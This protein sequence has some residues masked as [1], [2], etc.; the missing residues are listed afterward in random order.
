MSK[1]TECKD[2]GMLVSKRAKTCPHCG[3]RKPGVKP[4]NFGRL[5]LI[6][7]VIFIAGTVYV[8][9]LDLPDSP[10]AS[11]RA[12]P[13]MYTPKPRVY[14]DAEIHDAIKQSDDYETYRAE[15]AAAAR[16]LLESRRCGKYEM[17]EYGGFVKSPTYKVRLVY[18]T[19]CGGSH[20]DNRIYL[21]V[22]TGQIF[23]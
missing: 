5:F 22:S 15:F 17:T 13:A 14:T 21:D 19:Y 16:T 1:L 9:Q 4:T 10:T 11:R 20:L 8:N 6:A 12:N 23:K 18:F 2:C 7:L 3:V